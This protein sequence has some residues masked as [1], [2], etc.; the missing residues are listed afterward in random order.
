MKKIIVLFIFSIFIFGGVEAS[1]ER[2][3]YPKPVIVFGDEKQEIAKKETEQVEQKEEVKEETVQEVQEETEQPISVE[4]MEKTLEKYGKWVETKEYGR[5]W[6]P[7]ANQKDGWAPY[8]E[9]EWK[10][11]TKDKEKECRYWHSYEPYGYIVYHYGYWQWTPIWGWYW[12]PGYVWAPAWVYWYHWGSWVYWTPIWV[13]SWYYSRYAHNPRFWNVVRKTQ[14]RSTNL[15]AAIRSAQQ[16]NN[17]IQIP[18][19]QIVANVGPVSKN[20]A[21]NRLQNTSSQLSFQ[22]VRSSVIKKNTSNYNSSRDN[23][24][25]VDLRSKPPSS[26]APRK[27]ISFSRPSSRSQSPQPYRISAYQSVSRP[28]TIPRNNLLGR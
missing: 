7:S 3:K 25:R 15:Q 6:V 10:K 21:Q 17:L 1:Q 26:P 27:F 9:G 12:I 23:P 2:V 24:W 28:S 4:K 16:Q 19:S 20:L 5:V 22:H 13:D 18:A 8:K 11:E 14:L